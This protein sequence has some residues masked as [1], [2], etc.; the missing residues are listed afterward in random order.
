M[1]WGGV[2]GGGC[3][4]GRVRGSKMA[5]ML[6]T[7]YMDAPI[8]SFRNKYCILES[9]TRIGLNIKTNQI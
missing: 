4:Q 6:R 1:G 7:Y 3:V 5:K 2:G 9:I 8:V